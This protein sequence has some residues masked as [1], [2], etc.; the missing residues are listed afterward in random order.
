MRKIESFSNLPDKVPY[1]FW[2]SDK[3]ELYLT[4]GHV[5]DIPK[6]LEIAGVNPQVR[7]DKYRAL[8][9]LKWWRIRFVVTMGRSLHVENPEHQISLYQYKVAKDLTSWYSMEDLYVNNRR[10]KL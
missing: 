5:K 1:G 3:G 2:M 6:L 9:H 4:T 10:V 8:Y 7:Y